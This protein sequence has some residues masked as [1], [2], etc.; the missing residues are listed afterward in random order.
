[1]YIERENRS[2]HTR[3]EYK[4]QK[5]KN[6]MHSPEFMSTKTHLDY[7][8]LT[9]SQVEQVERFLFKEPHMLSFLDEQFKGSR[10]LIGN[11]ARNTP[12]IITYATQEVQNDKQFLYRLVRDN[13][14]C[15]PY[16]SESLKNDK[17]F[18][19]PF[20]NIYALTLQYAS[21]NLQNDKEFVWQALEGNVFAIQYA[22]EELK[23]DPEMIRKVLTNKGYA[24]KFFNESIQG[25]KEYVSMAVQKHGL[26]IRSASAELRQDKELAL[27][28]VKNRG[29]S[30]Q[31]VHAFMDDREVVA[32]A[33]DQEGMAFQY[34]SGPLKG[35]RGLAYTAFSKNEE[36]FNYVSDDL[37]NDY[38]FIRECLKGSSAQGQNIVLNQLGEKLRNN[39]KVMGILITRYP[40]AIEQIGEELKHNKDFGLLVVSNNGDNLRYLSESLQDNEDI[41]W[42]AMTNDRNAISYI[43]DRLKNDKELVMMGLA[44]K[45]KYSFNNGLQHASEDLRKDPDLVKYAI[46]IDPELFVDAHESLYKDKQF[47]LELIHDNV[48]MLKWL[49]TPMKND[50]DIVKCVIKKDYKL[51][52][53]VGKEIKNNPEIIGFLSQ[54]CTEEKFIK[55]NLGEKLKEEIGFHNWREYIDKANL[56]SKL[57]K[58]LNSSISNNSNN[59]SQDLPKKIK[60]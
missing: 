26:S 41:A 42:C 13:T 51:F 46:E 60:I 34:A 43:S 25:N 30:L 3:K 50:I 54:Y 38:S 6:I 27:I 53:F 47:N 49:Y 17:D 4:N 9:P 32:A 59:K 29:I 24:L 16:I 21:K 45:G 15:F 18:L 40:R 19:L 12:E 48:Y 28:A 11:L 39:A 2:Q 44:A 8:E 35:D 20:L 56:A 22:S 36:M 37:K 10:W 7:L 31:H 58:N 52:E 23:N 55:D 1:L 5:G 57:T 33:I 14:K